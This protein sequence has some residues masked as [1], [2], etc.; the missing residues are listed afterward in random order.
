MA[1]RANT[2]KQNDIAKELDAAYKEWRE[3][4]DKIRGHLGASVLGHKCVRA[5]YYSFRWAWLTSHKGRMLRLFD[6]GHDEEHR[7]KKWLR[8][9]GHE[10]VDRHPETGKQFQFHDHDGHMSGSCDGFVSPE[11]RLPLPKDNGWGL[12]E[13]KTH[14]DKSF[15]DLLKK[16]LAMSKISHYVQTHVYMR[17]FRVSWALYIPVNKNDDDIEPLVLQYKPEVGDY[18][19]GLA[20]D[21]IYAPGPPPRV[22]SDPSWWVCKMCDYHDVC[23]HGKDPHRNCRT[24]QFSQ[25]VQDGQWSCNKYGANIPTLEAQR[26]GCDLWDPIR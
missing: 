9:A 8:I 11:G 1:S 12:L 3:A 16:G 17:Y 4:N 20:K 19:S 7:I 5:V 25:P 22:S 21:I 18:Y 10:V 2:R 24:C 14:S 15:S 26:K 13:D 23:H 6:R